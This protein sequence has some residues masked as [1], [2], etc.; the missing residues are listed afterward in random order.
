[1]RFTKTRAN[2]PDDLDRL[3]HRDGPGAIEPGEQAFTLN[4]L[5]RGVRHTICAAKIVDPANVLVRNLPGEAQLP[6]E[7]L[8]HF[9]VGGNFGL[10]N[11]YGNDFVRFQVPDFVDDSHSAR[12]DLR[13]G[14]KPRRYA[15]GQG[16]PPP[17]FAVR[18]GAGPHNFEYVFFFRPPVDGE[19][20]EPRA[21]QIGLI[22]HRFV[23]G[24]GNEN[25]S[26]GRALHDARRYVDQIAE[27]VVPFA[28]ADAAV[29]PDAD[30]YALI[31]RKRLIQFEELAL[32]VH[33]CAHRGG[34]VGEFR[35]R[36]VADRLNNS[37]P[38]PCNDA[39]GQ[40]VMPMDHREAGRVAVALEESSRPGHV[41][42]EHSQGSL[43]PAELLVDL[44]SCL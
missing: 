19:L 16:G 12:A 1:M 6:L 25:L 30:F 10:E 40:L 31:C 28:V 42:K 35:H 14:W 13:H 5:H 37:A 4:E 29:N 38:V 22:L 23:D 8:L 32:D 17:F 34:W 18:F 7:I 43:V 24:P 20:I 11:L 33:G 36:G 39:G 27:Q 3:V 21:L 26:R 2:L 9:R 15:R 44:S 41:R